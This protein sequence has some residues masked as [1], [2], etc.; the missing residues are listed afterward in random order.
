M[1]TNLNITLAYNIVETN[2]KCIKKLQLTNT[3][4]ALNHVAT[5]TCRLPL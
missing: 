2:R 5:K 3:N 1:D 4:F